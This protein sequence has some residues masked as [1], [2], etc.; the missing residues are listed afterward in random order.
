VIKSGIEIG[1]DRFGL[2]VSYLIMIKL[3]L[4]FALVVVATRLFSLDLLDAVR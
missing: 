4:L 1:F 2:H 3:L